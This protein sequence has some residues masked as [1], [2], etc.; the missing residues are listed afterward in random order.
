[1]VVEDDPAIRAF[2]TLIL[3]QAGYE[4]LAAQGGKDALRLAGETAMIHL[5]VTDFTMPK[6]DGI[7]LAHRFR[8]MHPRT[9]VLLVSGSLP[10]TEHHTE[11][12]ERF[13]YLPKPFHIS[14]FLGKV[15]ALLDTAP[16]MP[17][18]ASA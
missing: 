16:P 15:R 5:L 4:V 14:E 9:P 18:C 17:S 12:L 13:E 1:M 3:R 10:L 7:E 6:I 2:E 11:D 8:D